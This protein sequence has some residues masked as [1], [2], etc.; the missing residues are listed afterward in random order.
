MTWSLIICHQNSLP[1]LAT[2]LLVTGSASSMLSMLDVK[3]NEQWAGLPRLIGSCTS[4]TCQQR[5][6]HNQILLRGELLDSAPKG[7]RAV[8]PCAPSPE[9]ALSLTQQWPSILL[10]WELWYMASI[11]LKSWP[12]RGSRT[13]RPK[14]HLFGTLIISS[15]LFLRDYWQS[16]PEHCEVTLL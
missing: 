4:N 11:R 9:L 6:T 3:R 16:G 12:L 2:R 1:A 13:C 7:P 10:A 15:W 14:I 5:A 8:S